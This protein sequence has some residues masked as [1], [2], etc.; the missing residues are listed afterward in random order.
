MCSSDLFPSHDRNAT[1]GSIRAIL[2]LVSTAFYLM[3]TDSLRFLATDE[4]LSQIADDCVDDLFSLLKSLCKEAGFS[5]LMVTHDQRF[6]P[7]FNMMYRI[8]KGGTFL[9]ELPDVR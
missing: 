4:A 7:Y 2:G 1:G 8:Q 9:K 5:F 3:K 6:M